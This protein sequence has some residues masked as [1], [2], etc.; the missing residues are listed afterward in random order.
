MYTLPWFYNSGKRGLIK[1]TGSALKEIQFVSW[2]ATLLAIF[3]AYNLLVN[4]LKHLVNVQI[5]HKSKSYKPIKFIKTICLI[6]HT[7]CCGVEN[8]EHELN[9][10]QLCIINL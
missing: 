5:S 7:I 2:S 9:R 6:G 1:F 4:F 8:T 3:M 10:I